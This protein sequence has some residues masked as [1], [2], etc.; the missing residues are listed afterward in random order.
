MA[1]VAL[2]TA[3]RQGPTPHSVAI[4]T[5][6]CGADR[7]TLVR[8]QRWW[9][10]SVIDSAEWRARR[11]RLREP[12]EPTLLPLGLFEQYW[13]Q[14]DQVATTVLAFKFLSP[15]SCPIRFEQIEG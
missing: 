15:L 1:T 8:W 2:I 4:L 9:R 14:G 5:R 12:I 7:R 10:E 13:N 6:E 3:L 11:S